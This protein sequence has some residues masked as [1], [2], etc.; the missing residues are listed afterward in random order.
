MV[1]GGEGLRHRR[2]T[3]PSMADQFETVADDWL[4][5]R[6]GPDAHEFLSRFEGADLVVVNGEGSIYRT[7]HTAIRELFL[8][9]LA[10]ERLGIPTVYVNGGLH[11]TGVMPILPAMVRKTFRRI[12][13]VALREAWSLRNVQEYVPDL[14]AALFPDTAFTLTPEDAH[15]SGDVAAHL[16]RLVGS[17]YFCFAPGAMPMDS[18]GGKKSALHQ[19]ISALKVAAPHAVFVSSNPADRYIEEIAHQTDSLFLERGT[20]Y[21]E[22]MAL[23]AGAQFLVSGR[24]HNVILAAIM[25]CPTIAFGSSSHKVHGGCEMLDNLI[26]SPYDGTDL[27]S[28]LDAIS[29]QAATY[30]E[31]RDGFTERLRVICQRRRDE[32]FELGSFVVNAMRSTS[33]AGQRHRGYSAT[34]APRVRRSTSDRRGHLSGQ[35]PWK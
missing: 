29:D 10:K 19:M 13:A 27:R 20:D 6:G 16:D 5:G 4:E 33:E 8:A 31:N 7:N 23:V 22:F 15:V 25:G 21:R 34:S 12:D 30:V 9:W 2:A 32:A 14:P 26:G 1:D 18:R 24:Y 11:L 3:F 17:P 28:E 35:D